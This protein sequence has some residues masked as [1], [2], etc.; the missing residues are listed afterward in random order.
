M[1]AY[2][3][4]EVYFYDAISDE[5]INNELE[6]IWKEVIVVGFLQITAELRHG[7]TE[8]LIHCYF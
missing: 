8:N 7:Q 5:L 3:A 4:V 2:R 1:K 6:R